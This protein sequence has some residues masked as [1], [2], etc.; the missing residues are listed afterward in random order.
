MQE[1]MKTIEDVIREE[2]KEKLDEET[3]KHQLE[4]GLVRKSVN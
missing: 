2:Y 4:V 1:N 3:A